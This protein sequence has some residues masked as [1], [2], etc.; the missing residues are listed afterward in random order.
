MDINDI[1]TKR[2]NEVLKFIQEKLG[3]DPSETLKAAEI[4]SIIEA[5]KK[6]PDNP[7]LYGDPLE[8]YISHRN[9]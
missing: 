6:R 3:I 2:D 9:Q 7:V 4:N 8:E 1:E 5:I